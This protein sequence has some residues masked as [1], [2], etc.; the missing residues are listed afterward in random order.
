MHHVY[1]IIMRIDTLICPNSKNNKTINLR[2][3]NYLFV[4]YIH[5]IRR[6]AKPKLLCVLAHH[7]QPYRSVP[8]WCIC[9]Y[10]CDVRY[11]QIGSI[12]MWGIFSYMPATLVSGIPIS[13]SMKVVFGGHFSSCLDPLVLDLPLKCI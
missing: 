13:T 1:L 9:T 11:I 2:R 8:D 4:K 12:P 6:G 7:L 5:V 10:Q 3:S